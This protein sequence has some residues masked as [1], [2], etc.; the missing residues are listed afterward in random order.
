MA[1]RFELTGIDIMIDKNLKNKTLFQLKEVV[2]NYN[3]KEYLAEYLFSFIQKRG[4][5]EI[6][7]IPN[8]SKDFRNQLI[9]DGYF[10]SSLKKVKVF[11]DPDG[12]V[13]YLF[14]LHDSKRIETVLL[15]DKKRITLCI[16][17]QSGCAMG[18]RFCA[19]AGLG[20]LRNLTADEIAEQVNIVC[21]DGYDITNIVFMGMGEPLANY[22]NVIKS[23]NILNNPKG[24]GIG[25]RRMTISSC[26]LTRQIKKLAEESVNPQLAVSLNAAD[27]KT[28]K[29]IMP[30]AERYPLRELLEAINFYIKS[31]NQRVTF[32]YV[33]LAGVND[34]TGCA[35]KLI[36]GIKKLNCNVNLIEFNPFPGCE[37][38][39]TQAK[40]IKSFANI[41]NNSGI[42]TTIRLKQGDTIKAACGQ[43]GAD[44]IR[45]V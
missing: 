14:E 24:R 26:G 40:G 12:T 10:I 15:F 31:T 28:R 23:V 17:T 7:Q 22:E 8:L 9:E 37:F 2:K 44:W 33:M 13:K 11:T 41:L 27:D 20:L 18:C 6:S 29:K 16:S 1:G 5:T 45:P 19:T 4:E 36:S 30:I 25:V 34:S 21:N 38:K 35:K 39:G 42:T 32:E 3:H 43:L